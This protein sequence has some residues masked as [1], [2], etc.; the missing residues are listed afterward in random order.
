MAEEKTEKEEKKEKT[1]KKEKVEK[2]EKDLGLDITNKLRENPWIISTIVVG[3]FAIVLLFFLFKGGVTGNV[4][5]ESDIGTQAVDFINT[6]VLQGQATVTLDSVSSKNGLY[7]VL[8]D[9]NNQKV[10]VYFTKDGQYYLGTQIVPTSLTASTSSQPETPA[11]VPKTD[12]P[13]V[14]LYVFS[15]CPYGTQAEKGILPVYNLLKNKADINIVFIGAMHGEFEKTESLRQLAIQKLYGKDKLFSYIDKF[16]SSADIGSCSGDDACLSPLLDKIYSQLG[17]NK[18]AVNTSMAKDAP[19]LYSADEAMA[20]S[21]GISG[22]PTLVV[23]GV[24]TQSGRD[25][26]SLL[27]TICSAFTTQPAEC[28]QSLSS[29]T[30]S[31]G[32]GSSSSTSS[33]ASAASCG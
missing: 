7:E 9:Y 22:S 28:S 29:A 4:V 2:T 5:S 31:P 12:K 14:D 21:L 32:F 24:E 20:Q 16:D 27:N 25:S 19:D 17:I 18:N 3:V 23:N 15:Y 11:E 6:Q 26:A 8:V 30:P 10:P 13:T 33:S 1:E